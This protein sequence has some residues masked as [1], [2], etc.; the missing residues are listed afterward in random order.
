M[1]KQIFIYF[2]LFVT[3]F[4][5]SCGETDKNTSETNTETENKVQVN[6]PKNFILDSLI[7]ANPNNPELYY[8]RSLFNYEKNFQAKALVDILTAIKLEKTTAKY[9]LLAGEV[10][11]AMSQ[12]QD[13]I[14]VINDGIQATKDN[15]ELYLRATEYNFYM[16]DYK[17]AMILVNDL[18][19]IN[20]NNA[21]A[22]FFKG[23]IYKNLN[24][25]DKAISSF[26]TC[27]EQDPTHYNAY[28]QLGILFSE[29]NNDF[30]INYFDNALRI[31]SDSREALYAKGYFYQQ[32]KQY[33]QAKQTYVQML[34]N[35]NKDFQ[36]FYN[37]GYCL[38]E[39]D[40]LQKSYKHFKIAANI[41]V[42][43]VD[44]IF[45][46]GQISER[47]GDI[48]NAKIQY[49]TALKLLPG[50]ETIQEA[51]DGVSNK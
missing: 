1:T 38:M 39:Q 50:N 8:N 47:I 46:M 33:N 37:I 28:M 13:A 12:G 44:A 22:Y 2:S 42:D 45:M 29:K 16:Q 43:Y 40:S 14:D 32:Q 25:K 15:E 31:R 10:Y 48:P 51:L 19:K 20:K 27:V 17:K 36:A 34:K 5:Y 6:K 49:H 9:Y 7:L 18:L 41:K 30:A 21:D 35:D 3:L 11:I 4:I 26:Q 24:D 23:L